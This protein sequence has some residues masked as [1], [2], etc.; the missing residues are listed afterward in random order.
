MQLSESK[1]VK[2]SKVCGFRL[3]S[4]SYPPPSPFSLIR[5][6]FHPICSG[7]LTCHSRIQR[8][9]GSSKKKLSQHR[10][11]TS[12]A[13]SHRDWSRLR[14]ERKRDDKRQTQLQMTF[15][16]SVLLALVSSYWAYKI[17]MPWIVCWDALTARAHCMCGTKSF[18]G[19]LFVCSSR[20]TS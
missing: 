6:P 9:R 19:D 15:L 7:S 2:C 13:R 14:N 10:S 18:S 17:R 3:I 4:S 1:L 5:P 8:Y 11:S 12:I 20:S 16:P